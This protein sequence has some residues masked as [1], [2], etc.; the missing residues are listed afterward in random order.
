MSPEKVVTD[1]DELRNLNFQCKCCMKDLRSSM[2]VLK[3]TVFS[4]IH[5]AEIAE[6]LMQNFILQL[7]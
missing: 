4:C 1:K 6:N 3:E 5:R 7:A 2:C